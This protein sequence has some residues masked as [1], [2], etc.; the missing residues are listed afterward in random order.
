MTV[1]YIVALI[2]EELGYAFTRK[3]NIIVQNAEELGYAFTRN[4]RIIALSADQ[5]AKAR[6]AAA[7]AA[8]A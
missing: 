4:T 3:T 1:C 2:A 7:R 6:L 5:A 8:G